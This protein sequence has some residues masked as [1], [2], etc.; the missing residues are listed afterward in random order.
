MKERMGISRH[1]SLSLSSSVRC[2]RDIKKDKEKEVDIVKSVTHYLLILDINNPKSQYH[3]APYSQELMVLP[4]PETLHM[5]PAGA[6]LV[7]RATACTSAL[8]VAGLLSLISM[9]SLLML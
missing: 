9:M 6:Q 7:G 5:V 2:D 1:C 4:Q 8:R 3:G